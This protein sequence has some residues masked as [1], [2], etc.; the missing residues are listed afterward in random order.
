[1]KEH[2]TLILKNYRKNRGGEYDTW[3]RLACEYLIERINENTLDLSQDLVGKLLYVIFLT[4][5]RGGRGR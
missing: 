3:I 1:M 2:L 4:A 5:R